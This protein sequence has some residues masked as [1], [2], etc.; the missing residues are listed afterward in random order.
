[1]PQAPPHV[2]ARHLA[3]GERAAHGEPGPPQPLRSG[4]DGR[5]PTPALPTTHLRVGAVGIGVVAL[6]LQAH[7]TK[8]GHDRRDLRLGAL[9][10]DVERE[11]VIDV[12]AGRAPVWTSGAGA[13]PTTNPSSPTP[14]RRMARSW[15]RCIHRSAQ[16]H[17]TRAT[18]TRGTTR[19]GAHSSCP[20]KMVSSNTPADKDR[21]VNKSLNPMGRPRR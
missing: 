18:H 4:A 11:E 14:L 16:V 1:M 9:P 7:P 6:H 20:C 17:P 19:V 2:E 5:G 15:I 8:L 10:L 21:I 3:L 12:V 13:P